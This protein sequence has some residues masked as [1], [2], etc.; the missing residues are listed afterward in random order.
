MRPVAE[1]I[2]RETDPA[3][4]RRFPQLDGLLRCGSRNLRSFW[5][6]DFVFAIHNHL[7]I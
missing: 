1:E 2:V 3:F 7:G 4:K 5:G 6:A